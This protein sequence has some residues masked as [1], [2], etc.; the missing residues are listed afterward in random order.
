MRTEI[1]IAITMAASAAMAVRYLDRDS[2][3]EAHAETAQ[4]DNR[5]RAG[6][7]NHLAAAQP[8]TVSW[9][10]EVRIRASHDNHYYVKAEINRQRA[11]FLVDTGASYVALRESVAHD[12]GVFLEK[13]DFDYPVRTAN[14]ET[15]AALVTLDEVEIDGI[16]IN[17]VKAF[18]LRD[19]QLAINL[20]GMSFLNRLESVEARRG[21]LI[22]KG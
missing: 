16:R 13:S 11:E 6:G 14:G 5:A 20:L 7:A 22:L 10:N 9:G 19:G 18:V 17:G 8:R 4:D 21:E 3:A 1:V 15:Y 2:T 12:A